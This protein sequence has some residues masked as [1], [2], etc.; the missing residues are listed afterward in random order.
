MC[1]WRL[2]A[3]VQ[4]RELEH[5]LRACSDGA[6]LTKEFR[7]LAN[8]VEGLRECSKEATIYAL[9]N[10]VREL[11]ADLS[12]RQAADREL[13]S[14]SAR[15]REL[16]QIVARKDDLLREQAEEMRLV[17]RKAEMA[18]A[19]AIAIPH[20]EAKLEFSSKTLLDAQCQIAELKKQNSTIAETLQTEVGGAVV[21]RNA[22][23]AGMEAARDGT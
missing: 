4:I 5:Q 13:E 14:K 3:R 22:G 21:C 23:G 20:L 7:G 2:R 15:I 16:E 11:L 18:E 8:L 1:R 12:V 9:Q 19:G 6:G 10:K 17:S